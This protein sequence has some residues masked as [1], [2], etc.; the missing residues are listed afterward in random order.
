M[1]HRGAQRSAEITH[2]S[3]AQEVPQPPSVVPKRAPLK[4]L[5]VEDDG[6]TRAALTRSVALL[7]DECRSAKDGFEAL[8][9]HQTDRA[10]V[11][12]SDWNMPRMNGVELC[13]RVRAEDGESNYTYFMLMTGQGDK[14]H[15]LRGMEAGADDYHP[16]PIDIDELRARLLSA[17]RVVTLYRKLADR[18]AT[19]RRDSQTSFRA[20]RLDPLTDVFNRL[21]LNEDFKTLSSRVKRYHYT[22]SAGLC[23]IDHFKEYN[24]R[25]GHIAGDGVLR[26]VAQAIRSSLRQG[27]DVYRYGGEEFLVILPH[28]TETEAARAM[29]RVRLAVEQLGIPTATGEVLTISVGV[30]A[31]DPA[32]DET[33][34]AWVARADVA[35]YASKA[36]GRNR[37]TVAPPST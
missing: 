18:N 7:G 19:L 27:D 26:R 22:Y 8:E 20:A 1:Q 34:D 3:A 24:D 16:K 31:L 13:R 33:L 29:E 21:R 14:D 5:V 17:A 30:A 4:V 25:Y 2:M 10:D 23:D 11:I 36:N 28:Q 37:I 32:R 35:L 6:P 12:V 9:M 15:Y